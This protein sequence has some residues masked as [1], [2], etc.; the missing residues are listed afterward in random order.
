MYIGIPTLMC[1]ISSYHKPV[2][3]K[4]SFESVSQKMKTDKAKKVLKESQE[5]IEK[6]NEQ[7]LTEDDLREYR[8]GI[9]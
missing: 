2:L 5:E 9:K 7:I 8:K 4:K 1:R 6:E 3:T